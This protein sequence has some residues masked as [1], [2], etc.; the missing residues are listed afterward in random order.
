M[1]L[2]PLTGRPAE[3]HQKKRQRHCAAALATSEAI[4]VL[5]DEKVFLNQPHLLA[6]AEHVVH[7]CG[8]S[9]TFNTSP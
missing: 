5:L 3:G 6:L 1:M 9:L 2:L 8:P 4:F 7:H